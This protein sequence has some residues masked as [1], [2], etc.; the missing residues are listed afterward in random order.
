M[1]GEDVGPWTEEEPDRELSSAPSSRWSS[2]R[3]VRGTGERIDT[4]RRTRSGHARRA[5]I[6]TG[7][8][9]TLRWIL[10]HLVEETARHNGHLDI[11]RELAD[12]TTGD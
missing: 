1:G 7:E 11:L 9:P 12:G 6:R 4:D 8:H 3:G 10:L 5:P 2:D